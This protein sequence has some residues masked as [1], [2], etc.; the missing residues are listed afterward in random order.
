MSTQFL[1]ID[2]GSSSLLLQFII[3]ICLGVA[4][5]F[6]TIVFKIKSLFGFPKNKEK[7]DERKH[8]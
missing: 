4:V 7:E 8:P 5:F 1:Y 2:P 3:G 6:K